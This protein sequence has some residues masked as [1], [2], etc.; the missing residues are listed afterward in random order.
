MRCSDIMGDCIA[1]KDSWPIAGPLAIGPLAVTQPPKV[2]ADGFSA[3]LPPMQPLS[4]QCPSFPGASSGG[5]L[6]QRKSHNCSLGSDCGVLRTMEGRGVCIQGLRRCAKPNLVWHQRGNENIQR[7]FYTCLLFVQN[8]GTKLRKL[9]NQPSK[10]DGAVVICFNNQSDR[11]S[12]RSKAKKLSETR[13][14]NSDPAWLQWPLCNLRVDL[15]PAG[16]LK[17]DFQ[18]RGALAGVLDKNV[19]ASVKDPP[20]WGS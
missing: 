18:S 16:V 14:V 15:L 1:K 4:S 19:S 12:N 17:Q 7:R 8:I 9:F 6:V 20:G 5:L 2:L 3:H 11:K 13:S 10:A